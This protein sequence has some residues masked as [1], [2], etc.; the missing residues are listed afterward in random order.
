MEIDHY[1][2]SKEMEYLLASYLFCNKPQMKRLLTYLVKHSYDEN[3]RAFDQRAI[4]VEC[5]GRRDDF[6]PAENPVVR[7]EVGRLRRLLN[8]FYEEELERSLSITIPLGQYRPIIEVQAASNECGFLP[9][10]A[11]MPA[12]PERLSLLLQFRTADKE[13]SA[14]YLLR[15]QLRIGFTLD[16]KKIPGI[17][18]VV[19]LPNE[20]GSV[21]DS[22]DFIMR[23]TVAKLEDG[24]FV[25]SKILRPDT[26][27]ELFRT[28]HQISEHY[29]EQKI[30]QLFHYFSSCFFDPSI[31]LLWPIWVR[32]REAQNHEESSPV[33][34]LMLYRKYQLVETKENFKNALGA[35]QSAA[36]RFPGDHL[37]S[38]VFVDLYFCDLIHGFGITNGS[39]EQGIGYAH[40]ALRFDPGCLRL[41]T[42]LALLTLFSGELA[43]A[44]MEVEEELKE[45]NSVNYSF[46][47]QRSVLQCLMGDWK[48]GFNQI[49]ALVEQFPRYPVLFPVLAY[50][51][52]VQNQ[53]LSAANRWCAEI[54]ANNG[55]A[56]IFQCIRFRVFSDDQSL[57]DIKRSQLRTLVSNHLR[58]YEN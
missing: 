18:L 5:L 15:H 55:E 52:A 56:T 31:G 53:D 9:E 47:F 25:S 39:L 49:E 37:L 35:V 12:S 1:E 2:L 43:I 14:L 41:H 20:D 24:F 17:R 23:V 21:A 51:N 3:E 10:L 36:S 4:A 19:A 44:R 11:S 46:L 48:E 29:N 7:I 58:Q 22:I 28:N 27:Q 45:V 32:M 40:E 26:E 38:F 54:K 42:L 8:S 30:Q 13:S 33:L 6:D 16:L 57:S 50:L 34:A